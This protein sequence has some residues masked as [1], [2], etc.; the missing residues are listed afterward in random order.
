[1]NRLLLKT[2]NIINFFALFYLFSSLIMYFFSP[3]ITVIFQPISIRHFNII[4]AIIYSIITFKLFLYNKKIIPCLILI[5]TLLL[6][7]IF[8]ST[9][10]YPYLQFIFGV[11][12][13]YYL[14]RIILT[15]KDINIKYSIHLAFIIEIIIFMLSLTILMS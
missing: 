9:I 2:L 3:S 5:I 7:I 12:I 6:E 8:N 1:M 15:K 11:I 13:F 14:I 4:L 10:F